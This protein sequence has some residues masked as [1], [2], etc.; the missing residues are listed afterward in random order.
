M[1]EKFTGAGAAVQRVKLLLT[2]LA[3][4]IRGLLPAPA[5]LLLIQAHASTLRK[6]EVAQVLLSMPPTRET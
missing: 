6:S 1:T 5:V 2:M 4:R 3:S